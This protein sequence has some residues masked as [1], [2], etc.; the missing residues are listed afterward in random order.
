MAEKE[1][2]KNEFIAEDNVVPEEKKKYKRNEYRKEY[3]KK[4]AKYR[5]EYAKENLK[6][7]LFR[8][9][10]NT[11]EGQKIIKKLESEDNINLYLR[12]LIL[13]DIKK[14][15]RKKKREEKKLNQVISNQI[16][17]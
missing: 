7:I 14:E 13:S 12:T 2:V 5:N 3:N 11:D 4:Y 6:V 10:K 15:E 17:E 1:Q 9:N 16:N 8:L